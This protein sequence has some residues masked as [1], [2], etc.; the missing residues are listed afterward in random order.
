MDVILSEEAQASESKDLTQKTSDEQ[1]PVFFCD[2]NRLQAVFYL[3]P[4]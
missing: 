3:N 4:K 2:A 1:S